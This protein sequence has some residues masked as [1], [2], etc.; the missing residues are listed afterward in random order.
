MLALARWLSETAAS[1]AIRQID[2]LVPVLQTIHILAI[3]I[4]LSSVLMVDLRV[5]FA[6]PA[7]PPPQDVARRFEA[8]I[9]SGL[10]VL[11]ASGAPLIVAEPQRTLLN[12]SFQ[13]KMALIVVAAVATYVL[14]QSLRRSADA[15]RAVGPRFLAGGTL[16]LWCMVAA[17]GRF[18]AY[19][20]PG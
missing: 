16:I 8:W 12:V 6:R 5:L 20:Q 13:I 18:I 10:I 9:W 15:R 17:A 7:M 11:A 19:T 4:V 14:L 1:G 2:G 3:A